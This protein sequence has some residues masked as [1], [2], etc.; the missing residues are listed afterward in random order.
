MS[1]DGVDKVFS[2]DLLARF[3]VLTRAS[4]LLTTDARVMN[5]LASTQRLMPPS[6][7]EMKQLLQGKKLGTDLTSILST[8]AVAADA[9]LSVA[10]TKYDKISFVGTH[11]GLIDTE[12]TRTTLPPWLETLKSILFR[13]SG[14]ALSEEE[15]GMIHA[16]ILAS[17]NVRSQQPSFFNSFYE[18][19]KPTPIAA[20]AIYGQWFWN[21]AENF[22]Q[23]HS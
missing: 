1:A 15:C 12:L 17:P 4:H 7:E 3:I 5:V 2:L 9:F 21:F 19:R 8:A 14:V 18:G 6:I 23:E 11:P 16:Q 10:S 20:D 13:Y 22:I